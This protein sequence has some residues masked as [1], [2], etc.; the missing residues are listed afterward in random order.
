MHKSHLKVHE[1][2]AVTEFFGGERK[3]LLG[4]SRGWLN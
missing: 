1:S 2:I 4:S 3:L